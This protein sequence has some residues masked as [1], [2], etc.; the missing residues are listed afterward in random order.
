MM[1]DLNGIIEETAKFHKENPQLEVFVQHVNSLVKK[2]D[3]DQLEE[4][5]GR[6]L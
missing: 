6:F 2:Y 4:L 5:I 1:G 3:L